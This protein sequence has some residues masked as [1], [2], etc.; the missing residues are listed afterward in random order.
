MRTSRARQTLSA[1]PVL[2]LIGQGLVPVVLASAGG[3]WATSPSVLG[4][5]PPAVQVHPPI[6]LVAASTTPTITTTAS[7]RGKSE[8]ASAGAKSGAAFC[9]SQALTYPPLLFTIA[10]L[11]FGLAIGAAHGG[12]TAAPLGSLQS[13]EAALGQAMGSVRVAEVLLE[14]AR[15]YAV[16][17]GVA[18]ADAGGEAASTIELGITELRAETPGSEALPYRFV[19]T[20]RG[21][22]VDRASGKVLDTFAHGEPTE[23]FTL[24][25]WTEDG[26]KRV[27]EQ[28]RLAAWRGVEAFVDE[29]VL[30]YRGA[31]SGSAKADG[32]AFRRSIPSYV[33]EPVQPTVAESTD[34][35][36][37]QFS[38][39]APTQDPQAVMFRWQPAPRSFAETGV[40]LDRLANLR[41]EL[42][43]F[44]ATP[45]PKQDGL[46]RAEPLLSTYGG[47][48]SPSLTL[49]ASLEP[50]KKYYWTVRATFLLDGQP[51]ATEWAHMDSQVDSSSM[52]RG[53]GAT[54]GYRAQWTHNQ[55]F[56]FLTTGPCR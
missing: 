41:Y 53:E 50:C 44:A 6:A 15:S 4:P 18:V 47:I 33:L 42:R 7:V 52:R 26:G 32:D 12:A 28:L 40:P 43:I 48:P 13:A 23:Q 34:V 31:P 10:C 19:L 8:G 39:F 11:P 30:A 46:Y 55:F 38:P 17:H 36:A 49:P 9:L 5:N 14:G 25:Q 54:P 45:D 24:V 20:V 51:R 37:R 29:W 35:R 1:S 21:Q 16:E 3:G 56:P 27:S 22:L 2:A